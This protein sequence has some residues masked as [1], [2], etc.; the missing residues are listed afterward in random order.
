MHNLAGELP[1][2][3]QY[4]SNV[5]RTAK[6]RYS[7]PGLRRPWMP[8]PEFHVAGDLAIDDRRDETVVGTPE[9]LASAVT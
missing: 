3:S 9:Q 6:L 4:R 1:S 2:P 8:R 7:R 5:Y